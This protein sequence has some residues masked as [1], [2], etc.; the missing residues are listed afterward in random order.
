MV[1][2]TAAYERDPGAQSYSPPRGDRPLGERGSHATNRPADGLEGASP[3]HAAALLAMGAVNQAA[4]RYSEAE[5]L[6]RKALDIGERSLGPDN[7]ALIAALTSL[8]SACVMCGKFD[9]ALQVATR[10]A[11]LSDNRL[12]EPEPDVVILITDLARLCLKQSAH[13][14]AEPLL[15][16]LLA[17]KRSKGEDHP[18][19]ATVLASLATVRQAL[20]RHESAEQLWRRVLE[21]RERTLA[22]NHFALAIALEHL[23]EAC[24]ARGKIGEA[25]QL[26]QRAQT[27][28]D[29]TLGAGHPSLQISRDRIA[30]L[31]LQAGESLDTPNDPPATALDKYRLLAPSND[32]GSQSMVSALPPLRERPAAARKGTAKIIERDRVVRQEPIVRQEAIVRQEPIVWQ[33][34]IVRQEPIIEEIAPP[35]PERSLADMA[36][37]D[38]QPAAAESAPYRDL[39]LSIQ[40]E[41]EEEEIDR[42]A[43]SGTGFFASIGPALRE[44]QRATLIGVGVLALVGILATVSR[45]WTDS[46]QS[47]TS[48]EA[49]VQPGRL[50]SPPGVDASG[51]GFIPANGPAAAPAAAAA[52][53]TPVTASRI[54]L[55]D[56]KPAAKKPTETRPEP[57]RITI[58]KV[59]SA[60]TAGFDSVVRARSGEGTAVGDQ[61]SVQPPPLAAAAKRIAFE[62]DDPT[63]L[64]QRAQLIGSLPV[65]RYPA[66]LRGETQG[67]VRVRVDVDTMGRPVMSSASVVS[68]PNSMLSAAVLKVIPNIRFEPARSGGPDSKRIADVVQLTFQ[69]RPTN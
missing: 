40:Q 6:F 8:A 34:P 23:A 63:N 69:F 39:I 54:R 50:V 64:A 61:F 67:E 55:A 4:G 48:V 20:G 10:V 66:Q 29:L 21:I 3:E 1:D 59:S 44:R 9:D 43:T 35:T 38:A 16:R 65:P 26:F 18:E 30:D 7:P 41:M 57:P 28:R 14:V 32:E 15:L 46:G 17:M 2:S 25:L 12:A 36:P 27:I 33:E 45:A 19:V 37:P 52:A 31:Q 68:S 62:G 47:A 60:L 56:Q 58:P 13:S 22:P 42:I 51:T 24:E 49:A 11:T 5:E 53:G